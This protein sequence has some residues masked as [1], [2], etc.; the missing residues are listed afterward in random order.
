[1]TLQEFV[2]LMNEDLKN[3]YKHLH[4]YL[5]S[6]V[7]V[8]GLHRHEVGEYLL[9]EAASEM[10][11]CEEFAR[12]IIGLGG[13]P[14]C[15]PARFPDT[16]TEPKAILEYV[17]EMEKEVVVNY[18]RRME[19]AEELGGYEGAVLH[20]FYENQLLDSRN[21]MEDVQ[22]MLRGLA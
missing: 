15:L 3:E 14:A 10:K 18:A 22:E 2:A 21:T 5:H 7:M 11:H 1:M 16:L 8:T 20:V 13:H 4:F 6:G 12:K 19:Q 17:F 9:A